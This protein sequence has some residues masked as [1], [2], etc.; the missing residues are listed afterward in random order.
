[1]TEAETSETTYRPR[2]M[3]ELS[4]AG[5]PLRESSAPVPKHWFSWRAVGPGLFVCLADTD[6]GCLIVAAQSGARWGYS[7]LF[8]QVI[9]IPVLF[10]AQELTIRLGVYTKQGH[11][12]CIRERFGPFWAWF[13]CTFLVIGCLFA[14]ISEM[15]GVASV[16]QLWG[17]SRT[18][19]TLLS[20]VII[21]TVVVG[22]NY[23]A[24]EAIGVV[25][26]LF[27]LTFVVAMCLVHPPLMEVLSGATKFY[28]KSEYVYLIAANIGAV[29]MPW[30]IYFQQSAVVA[31]RLRPGQEAAEERTQTLLG[32]CLTQLVMIAT[33]VTLAATKAR[34]ENLNSVKDIL[35]E[36][37][38]VLG[39]MR[40]KIFLSLAF[41]GGSLC[42]AFVVSLAASWAVCEAAGW[43]D[44]YSLDRPFKDAPRF[45]ATFL[46]VIVIGITV[47]LTGVNYVVLNVYIE[48]INALLMPM[49]I[50]FLYILA[51]GENL[52]PEIR[53]AGWHKNICAVVFSLCAT[54]ALVS[55]FWGVVG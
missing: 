42:A 55:A 4:T 49:A 19:G 18:T 39:E 8:L 50:G 26:G 51:T 3:A 24:I 21:V 38:P 31:R 33:L 46:S 47:L 10:L 36:L 17:L 41:V 15:S 52:P 22:C 12:A 44:P 37:S 48:L 34:Q 7:L 1:M 54:V 9:L 53:L 29:I 2:E 30:M 45:Y 32:S 23:K 40:A 5:T 25:L 11:T 35:T 6:A 13:S 43:D 20:A 27:E 16:A 14:T 28:A